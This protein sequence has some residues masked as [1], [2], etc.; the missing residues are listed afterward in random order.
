MLPGE[1]QIKE[2]IENEY[3]VGITIMFENEDSQYIAEQRVYDLLKKYNINIPLID[4]NLKEIEVQNRVI[5]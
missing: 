4:I 5:R 3:I 2:G 1:R